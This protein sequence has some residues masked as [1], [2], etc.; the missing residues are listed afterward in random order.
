[1][2]QPTFLSHRSSRPQRLR[3]V[4]LSIGLAFGL[5]PLAPLASHAG[6]VVVIGHASLS[7]IEATA[8][9]KI[10]TGKA[11]EVGGVPVTAINASSGSPLRQRFLQAFLN[12]DEEKYTA[13]WTVRRY[14]GKGAPPKEVA[15]PAEVISFVQSTP[16]AIGY[17]DEAD[18]KPGLNVL[19]KR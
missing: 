1:M 13:Y 19:A 8:V 15:S 10:F 14:I 9:E 7:R 11:I 2:N 4:L 17:I 6:S 3:R 12:Q 5:L 16:G 18:L